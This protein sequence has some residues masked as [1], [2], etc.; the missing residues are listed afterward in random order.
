[1]LSRLGRVEEAVASFEQ[2]IT[3]RPERPAAWDRKGNSLA[4]IGRY[5]EALTSLEKAIEIDSEYV[6]AWVNKGWVLQLM[7]RDAEAIAAYDRALEIRPGTGSYWGRKGNALE[8]VGRRGDAIAAY[9]KALEINPEDTLSRQRLRNLQSIPTP[10]PIQTGTRLCSPACR[11]A[12]SHVGH[13][14]TIDIHTQDIH[15][16]TPSR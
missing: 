3:L 11:S 15:V 16:D 2:A 14:Q 6:Y 13:T 5:E 4:M 9:T 1:M 10:P 12:S 7:N 8:A